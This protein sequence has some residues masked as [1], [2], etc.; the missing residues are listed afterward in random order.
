VN[1][2]TSERTDAESLLSH[3]RDD[4]NKMRRDDCHKTGREPCV[5][6]TFIL[7][8]PLWEMVAEVN[9]SSEHVLHVSTEEE[10]L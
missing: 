5:L 6:D 2:R 3:F 7:G 8:I 1:E 9:S 10:V 4:C